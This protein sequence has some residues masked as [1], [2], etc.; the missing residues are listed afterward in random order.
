MRKKIWKFS[1]Q[2]DNSIKMPK[3]A[4]ILSVQ[5]QND[6]FCI[7][8][9]VTPENELE[10]RYFQVYGTGSPIFE[11]SGF[12]K[13]YIAT[14]QFKDFVWHLFERINLKKTI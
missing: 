14:I 12:E 3:G 9:L 7:W 2:Y 4:E 8:A 13:K 5:K 6:V 10:E 1:F 11:D